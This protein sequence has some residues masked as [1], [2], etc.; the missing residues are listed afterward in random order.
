MCVY[1]YIYI[2][3]HTHTTNTNT[4]TNTNTTTSNT[5]NTN[6]NIYYAWTCGRAQ[7]S[8]S[9][10]ESL[11]IART[12]TPLRDRCWLLGLGAGS[13]GV[14]SQY[15]TYYNLIYYKLTYNTIQY[16]TNNTTY[17]HSKCIHVRKAVVL[18]Q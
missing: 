7:T 6:N 1:I 8:M 17:N 4:N 16:V 3:I 18:Y 2:Y 9:S 12:R 14:L 10:M 11:A 15:N 13:T 5:N